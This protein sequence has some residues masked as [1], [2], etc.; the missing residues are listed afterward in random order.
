MYRQ[1]HLLAAALMLL[2]GALPPAR[3][4]DSVVFDGERYI[5]MHRERQSPGDR[6]V[7]FVRE[8]ETLENWTQAIGY[9]RYRTKGNDPTRAA[10]EL[11][12][13]VKAANPDAETGIL[14]HTVT[15]DALIEF[16]TWPADG[17]HRE[18]TVVRYSRSAD[19]N[20]LVAFQFSH[21]FPGAMKDA[22]EHFDKKWVSWNSQA[23]E[24]DI[25]KVH[26]TF[27]D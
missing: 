19:G 4:Q 1:R 20:G 8:P 12:D 16:L 13:I 5:R 26:A 3:A 25:W 23:L 2:A 18:F 11:R 21:R 17:R 10:Y 15:R 6:M 7:Q 22:V 24:F 14:L 9:Y 27:G